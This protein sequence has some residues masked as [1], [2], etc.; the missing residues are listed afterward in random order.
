MG[1]RIISLADFRELKLDGNQGI[2][3]PTVRGTRKKPPRR[4]LVG[5]AAIHRSYPRNVSSKWQDYILMLKSIFIISCLA[6]VTLGL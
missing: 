1:G 4:N 3:K 6:L 5:L 2:A